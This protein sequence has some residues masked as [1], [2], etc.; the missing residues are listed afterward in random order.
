MSKTECPNC[1][2][3]KKSLGKHWDKAKDCSY[4][5]MSDKQIDT[6][7]GLILSDGTLTR[8]YK[9]PII[10]VKM[11]NK[12]YLEHLSSLFGVFGLGVKLH[13]TCD[14]QAQMNRESGFHEGALGENYQDVYRWMTRA[15]P[16][17]NMYRDWYCDEGKVFPE[18]LSI[19]PQLLKTWYA[20]DGDLSNGSIRIASTTQDMENILK[21]FSN[22]HIPNP[23]STNDRIYWTKSESEYV[24]DY[25][26]SSPPGFEYKWDESQ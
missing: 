12:K 17:L 20:G 21:Y 13:K 22:C 23:S 2:K 10:Q 5:N 7:T 4:P 14:E 18:Q 25:M 11:V 3:Y 1:G 24:F 26:G 19:S 6:A 16:D 15:H 9:N 8:N